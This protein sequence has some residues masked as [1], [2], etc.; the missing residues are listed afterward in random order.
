VITD[1]GVTFPKGNVA[2]LTETL[3][4]LCDDM[5]IVTRYK[6]QAAN[7][8]TAKYSWDDVTERTLELYQ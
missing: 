2:A 5:K 1:H 6:E 4:T 7:Y 8:I 3:Q